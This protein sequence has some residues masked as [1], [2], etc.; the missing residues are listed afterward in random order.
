ML[1][2][3]ELLLGQNLKNLINTPKRHQV[4]TNHHLVVIFHQ[5]LFILD[6]VLM[7]LDLI[8]VTSHVKELHIAVPEAT[9]HGS[10]LMRIH[11]TICPNRI[12]KL[13]YNSILRFLSSLVCW[14]LV[15]NQRNQFSSEKISNFSKS[16]CD[17]YNLSNSFKLY[18][19]PCKTVYKCIKLLYYIRFDES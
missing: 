14:F 19:K 2:K 4:A 1:K 16:I 3:D 8:V 11:R 10:H 12:Q 5:H 13:R 9:S 18:L 6:R 15:G 7:K 17:R